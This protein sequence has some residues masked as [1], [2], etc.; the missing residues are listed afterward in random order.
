MQA[1]LV[2]AHGSRREASNNEVRVLTTNIINQTDNPFELVETAFLELAE[3]SIPDGLEAC[4]KKGADAVVVFPYFLAAG[5]HV[6]TDI[7]NEIQPI[8]NKYPDVKITI[9]PHL[10]R[11]PQLTDAILALASS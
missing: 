2:V 11:S 5:T 1:L 10:G 4:I 3:P 6:V 8:S 7:P 9:A